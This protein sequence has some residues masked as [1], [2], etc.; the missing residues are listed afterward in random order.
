MDSETDLREKVQRANQ[1]RVLLNDPLL[2]ECLKD[3]RETVFYNIRT[4]HHDATEEREDLYR[5]LKAIDGFE[6]EFTRRI[7]DGK[8]AQSR[9]DQLINKIRRIA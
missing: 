7:S 6:R 3:M 2:Q 5:M 9:L 4:S 1:A 8:V